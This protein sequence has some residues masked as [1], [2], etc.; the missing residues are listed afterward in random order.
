M[1]TKAL[2]LV[3][4]F[5]V[6]QSFAESDSSS[7]LELIPHEGGFKFSASDHMMASSATEGDQS[8]ISVLK[9]L[10]ETEVGAEWGEYVASLGWT[11]RYASQGAVEPSRAL[12]IEKKSLH[13]EWKDWVFRLGD[14]HV[15]FGKGIALSLYRDQNFGVDTTLEGGYLRY[16]PSGWDTQVFAGRLN[17]WDNP[18]AIFNLE[19]PVASNEVV[20]AGASSKI[21]LSDTSQLG[22]HYLFAMRRP[23]LDTRYERRWNTMGLSFN[24]EGLFDTLDFYAETNLM[25]EDR[26]GDPN[27]YFPEAYGSYASFTWS[28]SPWKVKLEGKDYRNYRFDFRRPPTLEEDIVVSLNTENVSATRLMTERRFDGTVESVAASYLLGEDRAERASTALH[29]IVLSTKGVGLLDSHWEAKVGYR[30]LIELSDLAHV[31]FKLKVPTSKKQA[32]EMGYRKQLSRANLSQPELRQ[33]RNMMDVGYTFS[34]QL[35]ASLGYEF[36]PTA[37]E[38]NQNFVNLS[39]TLKMDALSTRALIGQTSGGTLCSAGVCRQVPP[40][41]GAYLELS[42]SL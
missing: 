12:Q 13:G 27:F 25:L 23:L 24:Q 5:V 7:A 37:N 6:S 29:H 2:L 30:R 40:F 35:S 14:T 17:G 33:D 8:D 9:I 4:L 28:S 36:I 19:N 22:G 16:H 38:A 31:A 42:Y 11:N 10:N 3:G 21:A 34:S 32:V 39:A 1:K 26:L 18:V 41:S 15:E 20:M